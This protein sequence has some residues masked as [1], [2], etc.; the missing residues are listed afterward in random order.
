M[1]KEFDPEGT[2]ETAL[3]PAG[4]ECL[5]YRGQPAIDLQGD[6]GHEPSFL[7]GEPKNGKRD[8]F[9]LSPAS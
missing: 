7:R 3:N 9:R 2:E 6:A 4:A 1:L 8:F 5:L